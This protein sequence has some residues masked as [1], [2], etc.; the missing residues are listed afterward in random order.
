MGNDEMLRWL[1]AQD[2]KRR[3]EM[4]RFI[5][6]EAG[7]LK[8]HH[9]TTLSE[10]LLEVLEHK[11]AEEAITALRSVSARVIMERST[12]TD[13]LQRKYDAFVDTLG[14]SIEANLKPWNQALTNR[15]KLKK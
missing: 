2:E 11:D 7:D 14:G 1:D 5:G 10:R 6:D 15:N 4:R 3:A 13:E 8:V 12:T 9:V